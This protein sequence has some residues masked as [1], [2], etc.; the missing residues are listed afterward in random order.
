MTNRPDYVIVIPA[1]YESVRLPGK[2]L[3]DINGR[4]LLEHVWR[5]ARAS[6]A[7]HVIIATDDQRIMAAA[8]SF[9]A[10]AVMTSARHQ[11]GSDRIAETAAFMAWDADQLIV[12]L[13]GDEPEMP[14]ECLDQVAGL[15]ASDGTAA[16]ATLY[17][18][19]ESSEEVLDPN[20]VKV[21]VNG[22]GDALFFSRSPIPYPRCEDS[23]E[24]A[25]QAGTQWFR[26]MGLYC[27]RRSTLEV[28]T[29]TPPTPL[30]QGEKLEQLRILESGGRIR[31]SRACSRIPTGVD[32][33]AD[34]SRVRESLKF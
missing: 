14:P 31:I 27:F 25:L 33:E 20:I 24:A 1:R 17:W 5:R 16:A 23:V 15:L 4:T 9:G 32:T 28:F 3:R 26:H 8:A 13:Q 2:I 29:S 30:E 18:P 34:L 10:E 7:K 22:Q 11:S 21:V 6:A 12:N 19:C